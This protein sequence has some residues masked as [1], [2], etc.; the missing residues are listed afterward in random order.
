MRTASRFTDALLV[1]GLSLMVIGAVDPLEGAVL[2]LPGVALVALAAWRTRAP[3]RQLAA[4]ALGLAV[5]GVAAMVALSALGGIGGKS[6]RP[7]WWGVTMLPYPLGWV[8]AL[9]A[10]VGLLRG[11]F[12]PAVSPHGPLAR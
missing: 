12:R 8:L 6:G 11:R 9:V 1:G 7:L 10:G 4:V 5:L 2:I 3:Q